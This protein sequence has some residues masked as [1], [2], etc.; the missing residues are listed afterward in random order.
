MKILEIKKINNKYLRFLLKKLFSI[1]FFI[2]KERIT[3]IQESYSGSNTYALNHFFSE[4]FK[5]K[6][7]VIHIN[8]DQ[9]IFKK[10]YYLASSKIIITTHASYKF[11]KKQ[12]AIQLWHGP[13]IKKVLVMEKQNN[14]SYKDGLSKIDFILSYSQTCSTFMNACMLANENQ[15]IVTGAPRNDFLFFD[16]KN[17]LINS[18]YKKKIIVAVTMNEKNDFKY[19]IFANEN[20]DK[21][22]VEMNYAIYIKPHPHDEQK[23]NK[24]AFS[25]FN[26]IFILADADFAKEEIDFYQVLNKFDLL[27]TDYSSIFFD[28]LLLD[29]PILFLEDK[30]FDRGFLVEDLETFIPG[31]LFNDLSQLKRYLLELDDIKE[32]FKTKRNFI[33]KQFHRYS[34][35]L[36]SKRIE[37]FINRINLND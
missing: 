21:F 17:N 28:Y 36:S 12:I 1:F 30:F 27:I 8:E 5:S 37:K 33:K 25:S 22:L 2:K 15:Y 7:E 26:N 18:N 10:Y 23:F 31:P 35:N 20:L 19:N 16:K 4:S 11:K 34:D 14:F 32:K 6:F 13:L 9:N 3:L 29:R 24:D